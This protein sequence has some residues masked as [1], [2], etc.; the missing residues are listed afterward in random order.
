MLRVWRCSIVRIS[1]HDPARVNKGCPGKRLRQLRNRIETFEMRWAMIRF[2]SH[3]SYPFHWA[4]KGSYN[5]AV[6]KIPTR[7]NGLKKM[8][9][10][11]K[12]PVDFERKLI[13]RKTPL[14]FPHQ[15]LCSTVT[16]PNNVYLANRNIWESPSNEACFC[17][18]VPSFDIDALWL[19]LDSSRR[20]G[21]L[22][23]IFNCPRGP[24]P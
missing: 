20:R 17:E 3:G 16:F 12:V 6:A 23:N 2:L 14:Y 9:G 4:A 15:E 22:N 24:T 5:E 1:W 18:L 19:Q 10:A 21:T 7:Y 11:Q 8:F 13:T